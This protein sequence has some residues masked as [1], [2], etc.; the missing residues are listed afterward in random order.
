M[1]YSIN[2]F[3]YLS[4]AVIKCRSSVANWERVSG[5]VVS[6]TYIDVG[7]QIPQSEVAGGLVPFGTNCT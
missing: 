1:L 7:R 4:S 2:L 3:N 6:P 5:P